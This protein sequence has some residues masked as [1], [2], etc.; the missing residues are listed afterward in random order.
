MKWYVYQ[1]DDLYE[2]KVLRDGLG[3]GMELIPPRHSWMG[4]LTSQIECVADP[5]E[6]DLFLVPQI[7][8]VLWNP[9]PRPY[10]DAMA[11]AWLESLPWF[12]EAKARHVIFLLGDPCD[13][14]ESCS[15]SIV[16]MPSCR[17]GSTAMAMHYFAELPDRAPLPINECPI[18]VG[19]QGSTVTGSGV[20]RRVFEALNRGTSYRIH[21]RNT[22]G[23]FHMSHAPDQLARL[24][25][26]YRDHLNQSR[27]IVCPRGDGLSSLRFFE[28]LA[29]GRIPILIADQTQLPLEDVIPY[30]EF[31]VRIPEAEV[32]HWEDWVTEFLDDHPDL[33]RASRLAAETS[34]TWFT[35][36]ALAR[37]VHASVAARGLAGRSAASFAESVI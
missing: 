8:N 26:E 27:F 13:L 11:S 9:L 28:A 17:R 4:M 16:F 25:A 5:D 21:C 3:F 29:W 12:E 7:L 22:G 36:D 31:V 20:R 35:F 10:L 6:A 30:D 34:R 23:Y 19:F 32:D 37:F 33:D 14:P 2:S 15:R 1:R 24:A 18:D